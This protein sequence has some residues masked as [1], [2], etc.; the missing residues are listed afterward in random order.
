MFLP[1]IKNNL[2][3]VPATTGL[4]SAPANKNSENASKTKK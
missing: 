3:G 1:S 2:I 4:G